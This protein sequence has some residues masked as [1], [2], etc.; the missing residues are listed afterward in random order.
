MTRRLFRILVLCLVAAVW[1]TVNHFSND[2]V[3]TLLD[4]AVPLLGGVLG[5]LFGRWVA[6]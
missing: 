3:W 6:P 4:A 2:G 1:S 5:F